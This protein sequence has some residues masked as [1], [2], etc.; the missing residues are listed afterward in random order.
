MAPGARQDNAELKCRI[1]KDLSERINDYRHAHKLAHRRDA[2][3]ELIEKGL[4][5]E[6]A[7]LENSNR[8]NGSGAETEEGQDV[9]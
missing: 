4:E 1:P 6:K 7:R 2:V 8:T 9:R 3:I 5:A